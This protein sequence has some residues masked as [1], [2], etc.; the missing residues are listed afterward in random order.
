[1]NYFTKHI[2]SRSDKSIAGEFSQ[3]TF[4]PFTLLALHGF[5]IPPRTEEARVL[6]DI[7]V[8][9]ALP[10]KDILVCRNAKIGQAEFEM[11]ADQAW[12]QLVVDAPGAPACARQTSRSYTVGIQNHEK[13]AELLVTHWKT[14]GGHWLFADWTLDLATDHSG[15][16]ALNQSYANIHELRAALLPS[17]NFAC[18]T[19]DD[20]LFDV[21][22]NCDLSRAL[23]V[24]N[25]A[26]NKYG[27]EMHLS[28]G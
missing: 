25:A 23:A 9:L 24:L 14:K 17:R 27:V 1:M 8:E 11:D 19:F 28:P 26:G 21:Y 12:P 16:K 18:L 13:L 6:V 2:E 5:Q 20:N 10:K 7:L 15:I 22:A 4:A 3:S